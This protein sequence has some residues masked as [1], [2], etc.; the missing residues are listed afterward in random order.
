MTS[1]SRTLIEARDVVGIDLECP[2]QQCKAR[3]FYPIGIPDPKIPFACHSCNTDWFA[4]APDPRSGAAA[5]KAIEQIKMLMRFFTFLD[6]SNRSD[7]YAK[8][9][10]Q[11]ANVQPSPV[12]HAD[13][14][15]D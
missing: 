5:S 4:L 6:T 14:E 12:G 11:V 13:D 2:N 10:L 1:E 8:V 7:I 15:K 3:A 9:R